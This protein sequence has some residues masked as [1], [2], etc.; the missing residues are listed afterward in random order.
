M[1]TVDYE[2]VVVDGDLGA[3]FTAKVFS[4]VLNLRKVEKLINRKLKQ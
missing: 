4:G 1:A 3:Q 2:E